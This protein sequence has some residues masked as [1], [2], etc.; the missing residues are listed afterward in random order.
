MTDADSI[1]TTDVHGSCV[2]CDG[3]L[4]PHH[5]V[6]VVGGAAFTLCSDEC[7]RAKRRD[8]AASLAVR[9]RRRLTQLV[10]V[11][12]F[13]AVC[14]TPH[15]GPPSLRK[16]LARLKPSASSPMAPLPGSFGPEW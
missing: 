3:S 10:V 5:F 14:V 1:E 4:R 2:W 7:L 6:Q 8:D 13:V 12:A 15:D 9:R 11:T 16:P